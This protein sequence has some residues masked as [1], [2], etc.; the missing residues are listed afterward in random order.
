MT[1]SIIHDQPA[2]P[3]WGSVDGYLETLREVEAKGWELYPYAFGIATSTA[4]NPT[5]SAEERL[6]RI[7]N[8]ETAMDT[9]NAER[10][11]AYEAAKASA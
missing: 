3:A 10:R 7:A 1:Q 9:L 6:R 4:S 2:S 8:L 5:Y 11:A